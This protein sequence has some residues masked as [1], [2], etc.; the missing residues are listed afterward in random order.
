[1]TSVEFLGAW[2]DG[3]AKVS[4]LTMSLIGAITLLA[5][6][7]I[8]Y[9]CLVSPQNICAIPVLGIPAEYIC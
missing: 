7:V 5:Y 6:T 3:F 9:Q 2:I 1:M 4:V 8:L